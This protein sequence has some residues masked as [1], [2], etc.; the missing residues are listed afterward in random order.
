MRA[1]EAVEPPPAL[2]KVCVSPA[3]IILLLRECATVTTPVTRSTATSDDKKA[4]KLMYRYFPML[5]A[6]CLFAPR[7]AGADPLFDDSWY[8]APMMSFI[9]DDLDRD[10][11][12]GLSGFQIGLGKELSD[13]N[14]IEFTIVGTSFNSDGFDVDQRQ[15]GVGAD[16]V[17]R[18]R[19]VDVFIPYAIA[20]AGYIKTQTDGL[21]TSA[22]DGGGLMASVAIG[23]MMP[24]NVFN[25]SL[26]SELRMRFDNSIGSRHDFM[27][28]I[29][30]QRNF[31]S[32][33][34]SIQDADG[35]GV[36]DGKDRCGGSSR[37]SEVDAYGCAITRQR[38][39]P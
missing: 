35:D 6:A 2:Q 31:G 18:F 29:G 8:L 24:L 32:K 1:I 20:G 15:W 19:Q 22:T 34:K 3:C 10:V 7:L 36:P 23:L 39:T 14:A 28:S 37:N 12:D 17:R 13:K 9:D 30:L 11:D 38:T 27:L 26:R 21:R 25:T 16:Y 33:P 5:V 4:P